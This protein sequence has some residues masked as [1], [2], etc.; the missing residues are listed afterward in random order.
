MTREFMR[1][2]L[3]AL[4]RIAKTRN[5]AELYMVLEDMSKHT[6][7]IDGNCVKVLDEMNVD[8]GNDRSVTVGLVL[9]IPK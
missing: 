4:T 3:S 7:S 1:V 8:I 9:S 6:I 2:R 5:I